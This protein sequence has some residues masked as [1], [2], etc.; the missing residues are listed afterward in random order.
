[1]D[2][3]I[4]RRLADKEAKATGKTLPTKLKAAVKPRS[5]IAGIVARV[6]EQAKAEGAEDISG[7]LIAAKVRDFVED[8]EDPARV[9]LVLREIVRRQGDDFTPLRDLTFA[10]FAFISY[11]LG[12]PPGAWKWA[13]WADGLPEGRTRYSIE[14]WLGLWEDALPLVDPESSHDHPWIAEA[15]LM[16]SRLEAGRI[17][18]EAGF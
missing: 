14:H 13:L 3:K 1:M 16:L 15:K 11:K 17:A 9:E 10:S 6:C 2:N 7:G 5:V 18:A 8:S 12:I 4:V